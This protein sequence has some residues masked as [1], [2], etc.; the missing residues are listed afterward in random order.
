M[1][2][3]LTTLNLARFLAENAPK[4]KEV[5]RNIQIISVV[6]TWKHSKFICRKYFMNALIDS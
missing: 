6:D 1:L 2:F 4:L 3:Y 5:D